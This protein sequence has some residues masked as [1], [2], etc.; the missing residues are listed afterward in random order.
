MS[1]TTTEEA[2][3]KVLFLDAYFIPETIAFTH[4]ENDIIDA[5]IKDGHEINVICPIPTR[6]IDKETAAKY[7]HIK[8]ETFFNGKVHVQRFWAPQENK[9]PITRA[10]RY[11]WCNLRQYQIGKKYKDTDLIF[12]ASTPPTQGLLMAMLRKKLKCRTLYSLQDVFPDSLVNTGMTKKGSILWNIG[13]VIEKIT[14]KN[15]DK[16]IVISEEFRKN[17][18]Q[19][20]VPDDKIEVIY[21]W[22]DT[23]RVQP[24]PKEHNKLFEEIGIS[25]EKF[26]VVYAGNLGASQ[27]ADIIIGAAQ[28][29]RET[30]NIQFAIFGGGSEYQAMKST[31]AELKLTNVILNPLLPQDRV[32]EVYSMGDIAL[33]T[34]KPGVGKSGMPSKTWSIM[35]CNTPIL[36]A[37]D[38]DSELA[39]IIKTSQGGICI[40]PGNP[41]ALSK[42]ILELYNAR[43]GLQVNSREYVE[44]YMSKKICVSKYE[45]ILKTV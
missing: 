39:E 45:E 7:R 37:F 22:I 43:D 16:I 32:P 33:I 36:A 9:N 8:H 18:I 3:M 5:L 20:G 13:R 40:E 19:K 26:T 35:A 24:I 15:I 11:F 6:G 31:V 28:Q 12:S 4:L 30:E 34:C 21:N 2:G 27:G 29:L 10:F 23:D 17:L 38:L 14:Y 41:S 44:K 42:A 25:R 1:I